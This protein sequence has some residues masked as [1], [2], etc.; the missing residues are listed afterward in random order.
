MSRSLSFVWPIQIVELVALSF[1][2]LAPYHSHFIFPGKYKYVGE[3]PYACDVCGKT[4]A[5]NHVLKLHQ[6]A[7]LGERLYKCTICSETYSSKKA[8]EAHIKMHGVSP[9]RQSPVPSTSTGPA[10]AVG[11]SSSSTAGTILA[12]QQHGRPSSNAVALPAVHN[13]HH[14]GRRPGRHPSTG[15]VFVEQANKRMAGHSAAADGNRSSNHHSLSSENSSSSELLDGSSAGNGN[16]LLME[17]RRHFPM[18]QHPASGVPWNMLNSLSR[19]GVAQHHLGQSQFEHH[20]SQQPGMPVSL[21]DRTGSNFAYPQLLNATRDRLVGLPVAAA[22]A[23][24]PKIGGRHNFSDH[25]QSL[26]QSSSNQ[27]ART[28]EKDFS[29]MTYLRPMPPLIPVTAAGPLMATSPTSLRSMDRLSGHSA[30][31]SSSAGPPPLHRLDGSSTSRGPP[32]KS[33][34]FR[35]CEGSGSTGDGG[36]NSESSDSPHSSASSSPSL[37]TMD[38]ATDS[39][40]APIPDALRSTSVI[41]FAHRPSSSSSPTSSK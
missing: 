1:Q 40:G 29:P 16:N 18:Q 8:L 2:H 26:K 13:D 11:T 39:Q 28:M 7:H 37:M 19:S 34:R 4:F 25:L 6:M 15:G 30:S 36:G 38:A 35:G 22:A 3:R 20:Q 27:P 41:R 10:S 31:D 17:A 5:Y 14:L 21:Q 24:D 12:A 32:R 33:S 23:G 9:T